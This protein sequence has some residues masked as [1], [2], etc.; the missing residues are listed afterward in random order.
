MTSPFFL[1]F[2]VA[3]CNWRYLFLKQTTE[4]NFVFSLSEMN[5]K[6]KGSIPMKMNN[7]EKEV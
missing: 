4:Q 6:K 3:R 5:V 1:L 7:L 2:A